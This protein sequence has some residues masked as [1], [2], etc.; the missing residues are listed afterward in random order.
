MDKP[1]AP[2]PERERLE[3]LCAAFVDA[4]FCEINSGFFST[5][6]RPDLNTQHRKE[7]IDTAWTDL[8]RYRRRLIKNLNGDSEIA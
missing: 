2:N 8:E 5:V 6:V 1:T 3:E 7:L 4:C